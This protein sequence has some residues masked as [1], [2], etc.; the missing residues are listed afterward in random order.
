MR[1]FQR[2]ASDLA[3]KDSEHIPF[4]EEPLAAK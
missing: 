4:A 3:R 2:K 1:E